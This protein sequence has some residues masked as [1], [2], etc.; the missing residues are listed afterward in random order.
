MADN[1][2][3]RM[4]TMS[5][6]DAPVPLSRRCSKCN[7]LFDTLQ[8]LDKHQK[9][10]GH[11]ACDQCN[12]TYFDPGSLDHRADQ[13]LNCPGCHKTFT[14]AGGWIAH[15]EN[16]LCPRIPS[17][18]VARLRD[19]MLK[20]GQALEFQNAS[21]VDFAAYNAYKN[22][23][24]APAGAS[25]TTA[26]SSV[27]TATHRPNIMPN[28]NKVYFRP[29]QF[30]KIEEDGYT[31]SGPEFPPL[32]GSNQSKQPDLLTGAGTDTYE[33]TSANA[34]GQNKVLFPKA[35]GAVPPPS[36]FSGNTRV[37][38]ARPTGLRPTSQR[39]TDPDDPGFNAAVFEDP[40]LHTF[41]CP[42][43]CKTKIKSGRGLITHL[44]S[45]AHS[46]TEITCTTCNNVFKSATALV[47]HT[48]A[49]QKCHVRQT[50]DF[51]GQLNQLTGGALD[52][53]EKTRLKNDTVKFLIDN[54]FVDSLRNPTSGPK[55]GLEME[56]NEKIKEAVKKKQDYWKHHEPDWN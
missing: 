15:V 31:P 46:E 55:T 11:F 10:K 41:K 51:R 35:Y 34:W 33:Q 28:V 44:K 47:Q 7:V 48:E 2:S 40:I 24:W 27:H 22:D 8:L 17:K 5:F 54:K 9:E 37:Q 13:E 26:R 50:P 52:I 49:T 18:D 14:R 12:N 56:E 38:P 1:M 43:G 45:E 6:E 21:Q 39:I 4:S 20:M 25:S 42:H 29:G 19:K 30:P 36:A 32:G 53:D 16:N 3:S 23:T